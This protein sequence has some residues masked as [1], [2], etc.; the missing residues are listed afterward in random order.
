MIAGRPAATIALPHRRQVQPIDPLDDKPSEMLLGKPLIERRR[1][2]KARLAI[3]LTEITH[4]W[5]SRQRIN[6][7]S[8]PRATYNPL[9]PTGCWRPD[10]GRQCWI[11]GPGS[12]IGPT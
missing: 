2:Q 8:I 7:A 10:P 3:K 12:F 11:L 4:R 6:C 1:K 5:A 9:S